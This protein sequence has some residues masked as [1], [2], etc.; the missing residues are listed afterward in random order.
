MLINI[1]REQKYS[2]CYIG[3][4]ILDFLKNKKN[5][6]CIEEIYELIKQKIDEKISIDYIYYALDWLYLISSIRL[7]GERVFLCY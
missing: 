3:Y 7:D 1:E 5:G 4:E 6:K 2:L